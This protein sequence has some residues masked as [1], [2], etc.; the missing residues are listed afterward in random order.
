MTNPKKSDDLFGQKETILIFEDDLLTE[1]S[2][3][4]SFIVASCNRRNCFKKNLYQN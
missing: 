1:Y 3:G 2:Y 4:Y